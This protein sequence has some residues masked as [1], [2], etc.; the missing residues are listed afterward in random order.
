MNQR[1]HDYYEQ[2]KELS[3]AVIESRDSLQQKQRAVEDAEYAYKDLMQHFNSVQSDF[4]HDLVS[5][6][7]EK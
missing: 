2:L 3:Q 1:F 4:I 5:G 7:L 6:C